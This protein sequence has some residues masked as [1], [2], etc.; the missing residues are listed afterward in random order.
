MDFFCYSAGTSPEPPSLP[1]EIRERA[2]RLGIVIGI[3]H[4]QIDQGGE[5]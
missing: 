5:E 3:D 4:Y 1:T 2:D